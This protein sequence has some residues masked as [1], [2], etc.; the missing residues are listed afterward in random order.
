MK[1]RIYNLSLIILMLL[2]ARVNAQMPAAITIE[3]ADATAWDEMTITLD[4]TQACTPD[5]RSNLVDAEVVKIH[6][7]AFRYENIDEWGTGWGQFGVD[8]NATPADGSS[9]ELVKNDDGTYSITFVPAEFYGVDEGVTIIGISAVFNNNSWD[10]EAKDY[11][12]SGC[13]DFHIPF[14]YT[15][16]E[17]SI[18]FNLDLTYQESLG[19]FAIDDPAYLIFDGQTYTMEQVIEGI[20]PVAKFTYTLK[21]GIVPDQS[22]T[23]KFKMNDQEESMERTVVG[24]ESLVIVSHY[25][26][27]EKPTPVT[28]TPADATGTDEITLTLNPSIACNEGEDLTGV[29]TIFMHSAAFTTDEID[30]WGTSN[31]GS[32][33]VGYNE[34]PL[35]GVHTLPALTDEDEDGIYSITFTP[36]DFYGIEEGTQIIGIA[37]VFNGGDWTN[38]AK[39]N[40]AGGCVDFMIPLEYGGSAVEY[41]YQSDVL[42]IFPNPVDELLYVKSKTTI[43][44]IT[45]TNLLG[46]TIS[47]IKLPE[48]SD[49]EINTSDFTQGV[50]FIVCEDTKGKKYTTKF[51]KR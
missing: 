2:S 36:Q 18:E 10:A 14:N 6:S 19:N 30:K 48:E 46:A 1:N 3:P 21:E 40:D 37:A 23:Y 4:P 27:D 31:W 26:N 39:D 28:I 24:G 20:I 15:S 41:I 8:Y 9:T 44:K 5:G 47:Y 38:V 32:A 22:Y 11:G 34:E 16:P 25:F 13:K 35:D 45:I 42:N 49:L 7:A 17:V 51:I 33:V 43:V 50:Y 12:E 29:D